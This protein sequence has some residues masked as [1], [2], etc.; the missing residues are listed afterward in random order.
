MNSA[1]ELL[2]IWKK[3]RMW[4]CQ[5]EDYFFHCKL[6]DIFLFTFYMAESLGWVEHC[7]NLKCTVHKRFKA[8]TQDLR[9]TTARQ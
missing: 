8:L 9:G 5:K 4:E 7:E 1:D 3:G 2:L 6:K